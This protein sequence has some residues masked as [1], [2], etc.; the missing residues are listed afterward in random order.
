M[1]TNAEKKVPPL[2]ARQLVPSASLSEVPP[3]R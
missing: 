3:A 2:V 1:I